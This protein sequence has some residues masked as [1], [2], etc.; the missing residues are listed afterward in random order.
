[1]NQS[2]EL[3]IVSFNIPYPPNYG[4]VIDVFYKIKTLNELGIQ[5]ILHCFKY[6][7]KESNELNKYCKKVYYYNRPKSF[8]YFFSK[9]PFI[10]I[11]RAS[12]DLYRNLTYDSI[13]ILFEGL[14][15]CYYLPKLL[16]NNRKIIVR[17][18]NIEHDYYLGLANKE[19]NLFKK[20][21]FLSESIKLKAFEK[22]L[23]TKSI[24][25]AITKKDQ[26]HFKN[27]NPNSFLIPA[28]H[29]YNAINILR[30]KGEYVL[31]HGD[32]SVNENID[33]VKFILKNISEKTFCKFIIAG[34]NPAKSLQK[35][36]SKHS[37]IELIP[38]PSN[39]EMYELI[40][41]AHINLLLTGQ[42]TGIKLKLLNSLHIGR[43]CIANL[44]MV[45]GTNLESLCQVKNT[46]TEI[47]KEINRLMQTSISDYEIKNRKE[48][49]LK[50]VNNSKNA[51]KLI[52]LLD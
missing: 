32:L 14:H 42:A 39:N 27:C 20:V 31:Y 17:T 35:L 9:Y 28:F 11:T 40:Q 22:T 19:R 52:N 29:P 21:F 46:P 5:V 47:I 30:D 7:R 48:I 24:I 10:V 13:P 45:K 37:N 25:A 8:R 41:N 43:F 26:L 6:D 44:E 36:I 34:R 4:G 16:K 1:M 12:S 3:H 51:Q 33:A 2:K 23:K 15:T 18:H 38:N 49:L 50:F